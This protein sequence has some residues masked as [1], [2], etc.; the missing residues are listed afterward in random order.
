MLPVDATPETS[1]LMNNPLLPL[2]V[3]GVRFERN[4]RA[5]LD[6]VSFVLPGGRIQVILGPNGAG[7]SLL[8]RLLHGL[9]TPDAGTIDWSGCSPATV[10]PRLGMVLQR[11]VMLRRSVLANMTYALARHNVPRSQRRTQAMEALQ[12]AELDQLAHQPAPR[13]SGGEAQRLA[14][15]R[16]WAQ[17][18]RVL[19]FDEPCANLDPRS[20]LKIEQLI[21]EIHASG[22]Q[23]ILT[24]HDLA[25]AKR[26]AEDVLF[27]ANGRIQE[28]SSA[29][30]FF[31]TPASPE[32]AAY[33][34]GEL[35]AG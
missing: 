13:L 19:F 10:Q 1:G 2:K 14:I 20:T 4:G 25:Q 22:T 6:D 32:A 34:A 5:L 31:N 11:P 21:R 23:V 12:R 30:Q 16:A 15:V 29:D 26:L 24:T 28:N 33:L 17:R 7:K 8:L 35:L 3:N 27:I 9:I 18:P